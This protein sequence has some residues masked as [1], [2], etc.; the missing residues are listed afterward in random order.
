MSIYPGYSPMVVRVLQKV[1]HPAHHRPAHYQRSDG[2]TVKH[3][4]AQHYRYIG[5]SYW[6]TRNLSNLSSDIPTM[7][8]SVYTY[9]GA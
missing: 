4:F 3:P 2:W 7:V 6:F 5:D 8:L 9:Q 1:V